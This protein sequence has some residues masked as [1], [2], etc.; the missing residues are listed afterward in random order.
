MVADD[1][2]SQT[3]A[4]GTQGCSAIVRSYGNQS[5]AIWDGNESHNILNSDQGRE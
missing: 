4:E 1:R 2:G 5:S 3:I